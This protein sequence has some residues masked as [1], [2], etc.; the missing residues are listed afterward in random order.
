MGSA[1]KQLNTPN[2]LGINRGGTGSNNGSILSTSSLLRITTAEGGILKFQENGGKIN[3]GGVVGDGLFNIRIYDEDYYSS[4]ATQGGTVESSYV[5]ESSGTE[6]YGN[7]TSMTFNN[8]P[9]S[10]YGFFVVDD[11][12]ATVLG[13]SY[14]VV[15]GIGNQ[16][17]VVCQGKQLLE[18]KTYSAVQA[19]NFPSIF[20]FTCYGTVTNCV[21]TINP[22]IANSVDSFYPVLSIGKNSEEWYSVFE[23]RLSTDQNSSYFG[24]GAGSKTILGYNNLVFGYNSHSINTFSNFNTIFGE[25]CLYNTLT[26]HN[27]V[28]V[29]RSIGQG[30]SPGNFDSNIMLGFNSVT[31]PN[32]SSSI[33]IGNSSHSQATLSSIVNLITIGHYNYVSEIGNNS[34]SFNIVLG[35]GAFNPTNTNYHNT[36]IGCNA[37]Y[38]S[39]GS[40]NVV[41]G[42]DNNNIATGVR[43]YCTYIGTQITSSSGNKTNEIVIG[44]GAIGKGDNTTVIGKSATV[45]TYLFGNVSIGT[46]TPSNPLDVTGAIISRYKANPSWPV[47]LNGYVATYV[48]DNS[49]TKVGRILPYNGSAYID[50]AIG[51]WNS[52]N[53]NI[54]LK[55]GG[56]VGIGIGNPTVKFDVNGT[57]RSNSQLI[58]TVALGTAP[59]AVTSATKVVNL[60]SDML[61]DYH[62]STISQMVRANHMLTG[63][64]VISFKK[65]TNQYDTHIKWS[66]RLI[67]IADGK[68]SDFNTAGYFDIVCPSNGTVITGANGSNITVTTDGVPLSSWQALYYILPIGSS[69]G[70]SDNANFRVV[71]YSADIQIPPNWVLI[72]HHNNDN[73]QIIPNFGFTGTINF[74]DGDAMT[75]T[76]EIRNG[77]IAS[78]IIV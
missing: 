64:G 49:G 34:S 67:L 68:G 71:Y 8:A 40:Y 59:L 12:N 55:N 15:Y 61:D 6:V 9:D 20:D 30:N 10:S 17:Y 78:W 63:G 38:N 53:P 70:N 42:S 25:N 36:I 39:D 74:M 7:S 47:D 58:S 56:N 4:I 33:I 66:Q 16:G 18:G 32:V 35:N 11:S 51:D 50:L 37:F 76:I 46:S 2:I 60:N 28:V 5:S 22:F 73:H 21:I 54:M 41:V 44:S 14:S 52:G 72:A 19:N 24:L 77:K 29:G 27:N 1:F 26:A 69:S 75:N 3:I 62:I 43:S 57:I 65:D 23:M 31:C 45:Y 13:I 48:Y